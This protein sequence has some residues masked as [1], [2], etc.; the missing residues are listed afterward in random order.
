[1][2][3]IDQ[4]SELIGD[5][6]DAALDETK[7]PAALE[8]ICTYV[9]GAVSALTSHDFRGAGASIHASWGDDPTYSKLYNEA[10]VRLNPAIPA[11][12]MQAEV[13]EVSTYLDLIPE[14]EY[15]NS[16]FF[17][18]WAG[19]QGYIDAVQATLEK[20][21]TSFSAAVVIRHERNGPVDEATRRRMR[22]LAPHLRRAVEIGKVIERR[23]VEAQTLTETLDGLAAAMFLVDAAATIVHANAGGRELLS[24]GTVLRGGSPRLAFRAAGLD[25]SLRDALAAASAGD[26]EMGARDITIPAG[27]TRTVDGW[28]TCSR[29]RRVPTVPPAPAMPRPPRCSCARPSSSCRGRSAP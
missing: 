9:Q 26:G 13:G 2:T 6:Y 28:C 27:C 22:L 15:R 4:V 25:Q 8:R 11:A 7:W 21:A 17:K 23:Q 18:E 5:I 16:P 24:A 20:S 29:S 3:E 1:M 19:P 10:Y 12:V 14:Q